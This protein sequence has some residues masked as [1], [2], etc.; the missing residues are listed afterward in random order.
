MA[1]AIDRPV[2][3]AA[4]IVD[5][6]PSDVKAL[7]VLRML[8]RRQFREVGGC[9][10]RLHCPCGSEIYLTNAYKCG[11]CG[12]WLCASCAQRHFGLALPCKTCVPPGEEPAAD[13]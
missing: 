7:G 8:L 3:I 12:V 1:V 13:D 10:T 5:S 11:F 4:A 9:N 6:P 2:S